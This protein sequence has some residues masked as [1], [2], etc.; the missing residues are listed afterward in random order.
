MILVVAMRKYKNK[1]SS[2]DEHE[3]C[4]LIKAI[5]ETAKYYMSQQF[6]YGMSVAMAANQSNMQKGA[7]LREIAKD[8]AMTAL[9]DEQR[10]SKRFNRRKFLFGV[11]AS[12]DA[13]KAFNEIEN[14]R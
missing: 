3:K 11:E 10:A 4:A 12:A 14:K 8:P 9:R 13:L 7:I 6:S 1:L 2:L 5:K